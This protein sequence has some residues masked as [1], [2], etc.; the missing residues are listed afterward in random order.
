ML[1]KKSNFFSLKLSIIIVL[2]A[3]ISIHATSDIPLSDAIKSTGTKLTQ[4]SSDDVCGARLCDEPMSIEEKI[5][6]FLSNIITEDRPGGTAQQSAFMV[7]GVAQ[8]AFTGSTSYIASDFGKKYSDDVLGFSLTPTTFW[9]MEIVG[10]NKDNRALFFISTEDNYKNFP[11][12]FTIL[13]TQSNDE[14][15]GSVDELEFLTSFIS[16]SY[17]ENFEITEA[18]IDSKS[19]MGTTQYNI[20]GNMIFDGSKGLIQIPFSSLFITD[21]DKMFVATLYSG[22]D[23]FE[24][25]LQEFQKSISTF[26]T[27]VSSTTSTPQ[28]KTTTSPSP[29]IPTTTPKTE[30]SDIVPPPTQPPATKPPTQP[31]TK[32]QIP[33][34]PQAETRS[35]PGD[36]K[37]VP[38]WIKSNAQWW[39]DGQ[40]SD[41]DFT[42]GIEWMI[43]NNVINIPGL[44]TEKQLTGQSSQQD[45]PNWVRNNAKWWADNLI[46]EDDFVSGIEWLV[47]EGIIRI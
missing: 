45:I 33:S 24:Q 25:S 38:S 28:P 23:D 31:P 22:V 41:G 26:S 3:I 40:I 18:S 4:I 35:I 13:G 11:P 42:K 29:K 36:T 46:T 5:Q 2:I 27:S 32:P 34:S 43:K 12:F 6:Q 10:D 20:S 30:K 9:K 44:V 8:Q 37:R 39:G 1:I 16:A 14:K 7:G 15:L 19:V 21:D 17:S 47:E